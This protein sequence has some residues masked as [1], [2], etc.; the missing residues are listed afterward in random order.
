MR[1]GLQFSRCVCFWRCFIL[2]HGSFLGCFLGVLRFS[3]DF[4]LFSLSFLGLIVIGF[5]EA[6][7]EQTT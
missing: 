4:F 7:P 6:D 5:V 2:F 3:D 1:K